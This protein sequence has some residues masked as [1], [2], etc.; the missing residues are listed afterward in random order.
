VD[1]ITYVS[2]DDVAPGKMVRA[3]IEEV[4][5]YDLVALA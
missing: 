3:V 5:T 1:G 4:K 2:G